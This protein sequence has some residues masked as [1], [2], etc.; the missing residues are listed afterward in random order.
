MGLF[1]ISTVLLGVMIA[2]KLIF[3]QIEPLILKHLS[4]VTPFLVLIMLFVVGILSFAFKKKIQKRPSETTKLSR[5]GI[6]ALVIT[7]FI[8][9]V[10]FY[11]NYQ[12]TSLGWDAVALYDARAKY[13]KEGIKFSEMNSLSKYDTQNGYYYSLYPPFTS[14]AHFLW[15]GL[16]RALPIG[17]FYWLIYLLFGLVVFLAT[18]EDL[19][20]N[21]STVLVFATLS[22]NTIFESSLVEY[23]NLPYSLYILLGVFLLMSYLKTKETWKL[24]FGVGL[25]ISSQWIRFLEPLWISAAVAYAIACYSDKKLR[26]GLI[27][28]G[29]FLLFGLIEFLSWSYFV[30]QMAKSPQIIA[31]DFLK[32]SEPIIGTFTG[33]M[34]KIFIFFVKSW[35]IILL[36]YIG[37]LLVD[38]KKSMRIPQILFLKVFITGCI[39]IYFAGLYFVSFQSDWWDELGNSLVR[40]STFLIP[41]SGYLL[42]SYLFKDRYSR[43]ETNKTK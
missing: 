20:V 21:L 18:K 15:S 25:V 7:L 42:L 38:L 24:L 19:G 29:G 1:I 31:I 13:L 4:T 22:N 26:R 28:S 35:G 27:F 8:V 39:F 12:K 2:E 40:S 14:I 43:H 32:V 23:T 41:I 10:S 9:S 3:L 6:L 30:N 34:L 5:I 33:T 16:F 17:L 36:V 11:L 37:S